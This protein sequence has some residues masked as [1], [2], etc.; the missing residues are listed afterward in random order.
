MSVINLDGS[1]YELEHLSDTARQQ[2]IYIHHI[3]ER[4]LEIRSTLVIYQVAGKGL[5]GGDRESVE[6]KIQEC[7]LETAMLN[8]ARGQFLK[9]FRDSLN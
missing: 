8:A 7:H 9:S 1:E 5:V 4:L 6:A 3:D 2:L